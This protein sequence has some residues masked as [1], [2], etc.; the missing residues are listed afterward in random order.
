MNDKRH[1][2]TMPE[3]WT[4]KNLHSVYTRC[5]S[6]MTWGICM[7]QD[8]V[9]GNCGST[10]TVEYW[11]AKTIQ[12]ELSRLKQ[13]NGECRTGAKET[14]AEILRRAKEFCERTFKKHPD[15][16]LVRAG[17]DC[18]ADHLRLELEQIIKEVTGEG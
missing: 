5:F 1:E 16:P 9:C 8:N 4:G 6:C 7:P 18:T 3:S 15:S 12:S 11:D 10:E 17:Q 13:E 2:T 14:A